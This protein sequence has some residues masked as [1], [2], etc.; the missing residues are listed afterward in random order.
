MTHKKYFPLLFYYLLTIG[1]YLLAGCYSNKRIVIDDALNTGSERWKAKIK[2]GTTAI[3]RT[4]FGP[5][6]T[7]N[8][9]K[10]DSPKLKSRSDGFFSIHIFRNEQTK[11]KRKVYSLTTTLNKD[12]ATVLIQV[13]ITTASSEPGMINLFG[14]YDSHPVSKSKTASGEI[15]INNDSSLWS[16]KIEYYYLDPFGVSD[17][18][19]A[20]SGFLVSDYD[21]INISHA[22]EFTDGKQG[23]GVSKGINLNNKTG[24]I[25]ALQLIGDKNVWIRSDLPVKTQLVIATFFCAVLGTKDL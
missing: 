1:F 24:Q 6:N 23:Y 8:C 7:I 17:S 14:D 13:W 9:S 12:T 4:N 19:R 3:G 22:S 5:F 25:A 18:Y 16:F 21:I 20:T 11:T 2:N 10:L 15:S